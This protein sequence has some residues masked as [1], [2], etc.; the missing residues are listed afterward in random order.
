MRNRHRE[1]VSLTSAIALA[2]SMLVFVTFMAAPALARVCGPVTIEDG[3]ASPGKG[4]TATNF[5]FTV[6]FQDSNGGGPASINVIFPELGSTYDTA[7]MSSGTATFSGS[8][9]LPAG[10]WLYQFGAVSSGTACTQIQPSP[11]RV[12]VTTAPT[13]APT[14]VATPSPKPSP[15]PTPK[16]VAVVSPSPLPSDVGSATGGASPSPSAQAVILPKPT[17]SPAAGAG[18]TSASSGSGSAAGGPGE[19]LG[20]VLGLVT[21]PDPLL[22]WLIA[23]AGGILL[24]LVLM[25]RSR[26]RDGEVGAPYVQATPFA[27]ALPAPIADARPRKA[28]EALPETPVPAEAMEAA[29]IA[30]T[31]VTAA[32]AEITAAAATARPVRGALVFAE[33]PAM[34]VER[35]KVGYRKV[36]LSERVDDV[37]SRELGRLDPGDE[38]EVVGSF[39]GFLQVL[40]P[41]GQTGWIPRHTILG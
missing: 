32:V 15:A 29:A 39:E 8:R 26:E 28:A 11:R 33:P 1:R 24:F 41:D 20:A 34:G 31:A 5:T 16:T 12:L 30:E 38:V 7:L 3:N 37:V 13:P 22:A 19:G 17:S 4:T 36:R 2:A 14:A 35:L 10:N 9:K 25:R 6:R 18:G 27:T 40:T 21:N 23:T